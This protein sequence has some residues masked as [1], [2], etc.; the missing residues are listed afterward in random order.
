MRQCSCSSAPAGARLAFRMEH[1]SDLA[2]LLRRMEQVD[3]PPT[4]VLVQEPRIAGR[5]VGDTRVERLGKLPLPPRTLALHALR[6][7]LFAGLG[8]PR[9]VEG[10]PALA[11][12]IV[13]RQGSDCRLAV[14]RVFG[15]GVIAPSRPTTSVAIGASST[16]SQRHVSL[17]IPFEGIL[18]PR[19]LGPWRQSVMPGFALRS[20]PYPTSI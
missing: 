10:L 16:S 6:E 1:L 20:L 19:G 13:E 17:L 14:A 2:D 7:R 8:R 5:L 9:D 12:M 4:R 3:Q 11:V 15:H 18:L